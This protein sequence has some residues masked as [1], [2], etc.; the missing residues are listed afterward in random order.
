[1]ADADGEEAFTLKQLAREE[2]LS[3]E[4]H[5]KLADALLEEEFNYLR[6]VDVI[7]DTDIGQGLKFLPRKFADL[8]KNLQIWL[9]DVTETGRPDVRNKVD[10]VLEELLRRNGIS[11]E[12]YTSIKEDNNIL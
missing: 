9:E 2:L 12:K 10:A 1:M 4:Q 8:T 6:L 7:K 3:E 5:L 11:G